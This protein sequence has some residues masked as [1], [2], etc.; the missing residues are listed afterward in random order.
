MDRIY[1]MLKYLKQRGQ[2]LVEFAIMLPLFLAIFFS[3]A[4]GGVVFADYLILSNTARSC[5]RDAIVNYQIDSNTKNA[6]F[7]KVLGRAAKNKNNLLSRAF[8]W[9]ADEN[10]SNNRFLTIKEDTDNPVKDSNDKIT[11]YNITVTLNADLDTEKSYLAKMAYNFIN[12]T[13]GEQEVNK[14]MQNFIHIEYT[15]FREAT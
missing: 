9:N 2:A 14:Y 4:Y 8:I 13:S 1:T 6:T 11:G 12:F 10:G 15:M 3:I 7:K 5:A